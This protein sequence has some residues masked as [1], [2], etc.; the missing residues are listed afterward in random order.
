MRRSGRAR[1]LTAVSLLLM[2]ALA[3]WTWWRLQPVE[4]PAAFPGRLLGLPLSQRIYSG[5]AVEALDQVAG[6]N[7]PMSN[8]EVLVYGGADRDLHLW[9]G[10]TGSAAEARTAAGILAAGVAGGGVA[11]PLAEGNLGPSGGAPGYNRVWP[12]GRH[13]FWLHTDFRLSS[14]QLQSLLDEL[15]RLD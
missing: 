3:A 7:L 6:Q 11:E 14:T 10:Y 15:S 1:W 8:A 9:V 13:F 2:I 4:K 12:S 5:H